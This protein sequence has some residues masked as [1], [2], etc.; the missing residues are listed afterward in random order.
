MLAW[1]VSLWTSKQRIL[2]C[3]ASVKGGGCNLGYEGEV[4]NPGF[5]VSLCSLGQDASRKGSKT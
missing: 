4:R 1:A 3:G 5:G 2:R